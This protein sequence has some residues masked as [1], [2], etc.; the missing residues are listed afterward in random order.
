MNINLTD[1]DIILLEHIAI[2]HSIKILRND[3][4]EQATFLLQYAST[5]D[6]THLKKLKDNHLK[7]TDS[8]KS[9]HNLL[10]QHCSDEEKM[11]SEVLGN[12]ITKGNVIEHKEIGKFFNQAELILNETQLIGNL[13]P[14]EVMKAIYKVQQTVEMICSFIDTHETNEVG[15]LTLLKRVI[16]MDELGTGEPEIISSTLVDN[17]MNG[18]I[19]EH[20]AIKAQMKF[21]TESLANLASQSIHL[22]DQIK[23][24]RLA[25]CDFQDGL[26]YHIELDERIFKLILDKPSIEELIREHKQIQNQVKDIIKLVDSFVEDLTPEE[27]TQFDSNVRGAVNIMCKSIEAHTK[28]EDKLLKLVQAD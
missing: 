9:F 27:L 19:Q 3:M 11:L 15:M 17:E 8:L 4:A 7:L 24:Y 18:L 25:L 14:Q 20:K 21:L 22:N 23:S 1:I 26:Q 28:K 13:K 10:I 2:K 12:M 5:W 6:R 16:A